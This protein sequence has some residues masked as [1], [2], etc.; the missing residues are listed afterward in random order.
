VPDGS[1]AYVFS[2]AVIEHF[3]LPAARQV[4]AHAHAALRPGGTIRLMTPD[5]EAT[6]RLYLG[7]GALADEHLDRQRRFY[8]DVAHPVDLLR[9]LFTTSGH[10]LGYL[11]DEQSLTDELIGAG[12]ADIR[13]CD[14][15]ESADS[16]LRNLEKP[17]GTASEVATTLV[18]EATR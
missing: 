3:P 16:A 2:D 18:L 9:V 4:L 5:T 15:F 8:E 17:A 14:V 6:A 12:F 1:V 7:G 10:H 11:W 13:R